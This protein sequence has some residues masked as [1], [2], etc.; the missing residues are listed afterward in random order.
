MCVLFSEVVWFHP[1]LTHMF[2][3]TQ[4]VNLL[5]L[6]LVLSMRLFRLHWFDRREYRIDIG[7]ST[8]ILNI[9]FWQPLSS[10]P[11]IVHCLEFGLVDCQATLLQSLCVLIP[12]Q[13]NVL[14]LIATIP[15]HTNI[16]LLYYC[17]RLLYFWRIICVLNSNTIYFQYFFHFAHDISKIYTLHV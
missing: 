4:L 7:H 10:A 13:L 1:T 14:A 3:V 9:C 2:A 17:I 12:D 5:P 8:Y 15:I 11:H 16:A 6:P